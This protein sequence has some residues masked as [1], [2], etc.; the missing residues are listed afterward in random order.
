[1]ES[2]DYKKVYDMIPQSWIIK[3]IKMYKIS[4]EVM[5]FI[6]KSMNTWRVELTI[7][8]ESLAAAKIQ[9]GIFQGDAL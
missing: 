4:D 1:M 8:G 2:I 7:G 3:C 9:G 6:E 5:N